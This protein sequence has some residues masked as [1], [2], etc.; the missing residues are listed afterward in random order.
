[1][2][3][4]RILGVVALVHGLVAWSV[5]AWGADFSRDV[6]KALKTIRPKEC[7]EHIKLLASDGLEGRAVGTEGGRLA[8]E[9]IAR[10][11]D[12]MGLEPGGVN[13]TFFQP[14]SLRGRKSHEGDL[15]LTN[16]LFHQRRRGA[17]EY[18]LELNR[19]YA[20]V[21]SSA[22]GRAAGPLR[23]FRSFDKIP[24]ADGGWIAAVLGPVDKEARENLIKGGYRAILVLDN[25]SDELEVWPPQGSDKPSSTRSPQAV[26]DSSEADPE[27]APTPARMIEVRLTKKGTQQL[28]RKF[29]SGWG[30]LERE[31]EGV[32]DLDRGRACVRV[33]RRGYAYNRGRNVIAGLEGHDPKLKDEIVVIGAHYDH[34]GKPQEKRLTRGTLGEIHNGADDNASGISG[35]IELAEAF[36]ESQLKPSRTIVFIAFDAEEYGLLG[37]KYYVE[38]P[39]QYSIDKTVCM[40]NMDMISR[41]KPRDMFICRV[42]KYQGLNDIVTRV[43]TDVKINLNPEGMEKYLERSDHWPF[44][45]AGVPATFIFGGFHEDYHTENDDYQ[46]TNPTKTTDIAKLMFLCAYRCSEHQGTFR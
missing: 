21:H 27:P 29:G 39:P 10:A 13:G 24:S 32:I 8:G 45:Q 23:V 44:M 18:E 46:K 28:L 19:E 6:V 1:M 9:Y 11:F 7:F 4:I 12:E 34:V 26:E 30:E 3:P 41:N 2:K 35:L 33:S 17:R 43:S 36:A 20:P 16:G 5:A 22:E 38:D 15:E 14:F 37:S 31:T 40:I 42:D 25:E